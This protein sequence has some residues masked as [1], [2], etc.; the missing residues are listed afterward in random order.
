MTIIPG[1]NLCHGGVLSLAPD[2]AEI[3]PYYLLGVCNSTIFW[4]FVQ[5]RMPTMGNGRHT[6]RLERLRQFP[7][8]VPCPDNQ[9]SVQ[10][11]ATAAQSLVVDPVPLRRKE[12]IAEID[13]MV[14]KLYGMPKS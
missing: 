3:D 2:S 7:L 10:A 5:H 11:I 12:M 13:R 4:T 1:T 14:R 8:V 9:G 6:I